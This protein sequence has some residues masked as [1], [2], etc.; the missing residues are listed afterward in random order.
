MPEAK[1][2]TVLSFD[3]GTKSIGVA[4]GQ[5]ITGTASPLAALKAQ[6]GVPDWN[7]VKALYSEWQPD[8]VV[9]GL[10][11]N[12]DGTE[13]TVTLLA[14]RF[15]NRLLG[16]F[17]VAVETWDERLSTADAKAM[18][19]ELGGY[20]KLTKDKVDSVSACVIFTSWAENQFQ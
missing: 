18:L 4:V 9:V 16:R 19:F 20:K 14:K 11:L 7:K 13:Q 6:D 2:R 10:P 15:A 17:N 3:F 8:L 5:E 1:S 12:M